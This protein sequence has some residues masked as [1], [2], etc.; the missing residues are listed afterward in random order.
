[1]Q[2]YASLVQNPGSSLVSCHVTSSLP[3]DVFPPEVAQSERGSSIPGRE[4]YYRTRLFPD[5]QLSALRAFC[6]HGSLRVP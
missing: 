1:M 4:D 6:G 2:I 5:D 3:L